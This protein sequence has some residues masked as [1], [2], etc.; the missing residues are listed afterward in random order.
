MGFEIK[1]SNIGVER[2]VKE[3]GVQTY[4]ALDVSGSVRMTLTP[5]S[6]PICKLLNTHASSWVLVDS[7]HL[8]DLKQDASQWQKVVEALCDLSLEIVQS[9]K[10]KVL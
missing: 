8:D 10:R 3:R 5:D 7:A 1:F 2:S 6:G 4:T 9:V